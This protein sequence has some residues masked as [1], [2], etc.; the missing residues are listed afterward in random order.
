MNN[1]TITYG[2]G[3]HHV[4]TDPLYQGDY[5]QQI[6]FAGIDGLPASFEVHFSNEA[7]MGISTRAI[8]LDSVVNIPNMYLQTGEVS[9]YGWVFLHDPATSGETEYTFRIPVKKKPAADPVIPTPPQE[10]VIAE[11]INAINGAAEDAAQSATDAQTAQGLAEDARD[12]AQV[13][14]GKAEDAQE[15]AETA[16]GK[17]ED[18]Q[19]AAE[20][21]QG[22]AEDAQ[23]AAE[24]VAHSITDMTVSAS[25]LEPGS[26]ATVTKTFS[27]GVY[28]LVFGLPEGEKGDTGATG[29]TGAQGP[30]GETGATGA[31]GP[32][33][34][35]GAT[36]ATGAQGPRGE[37]GATG[38]T[39]DFSIG[40]VTTGAA[41]SSA[42]A[43]ITGTAAAPVLNLTIPK[44]DPG[45]ATIDDT[46]GDGDTDKVW[47]ADKCYDEV[48]DL[49]SHKSDIDGTYP[50][51][52]SGN[53]LQLL[54][55][56]GTTDKV[57]YFFRPSFAGDR[58]TDKLV[59]GSI[60]WN[61]LIQ[62]GKAPS[63]PPWDARNGT[64]TAGENESVY[65]VTTL[66]T[67][68]SI[69]VAING[70]ANHVYLFSVDVNP[71]HSKTALDMIIDYRT[72]RSSG[73]VS[74]TQGRWSTI[75]VVSLVS[76]ETGLRE[77]QIFLNCTEENGY[78]VGDKDK[79][80]NFMC[81][82][83][84]KMFGS[85]IANYIYSLEQATAGAGV[86]W[87]KKLFPKPYYAYNAGEIMS[88]SGVSAHQMTGFNQWDE[89][90]EQGEINTGT[91]ADS[92]STEK[93][94]SKNYI[95]ISPDW[96]Y[97]AKAP[98]S[99]YL[100]F[101]DAE[102]NY[103]GFHGSSKKDSVFRPYELSNAKPNGTSFENAV[104]MRF[105]C[106][107]ST[108]NHDICI[109]LHWDGE[110]D[111][112]YEPYV[113][114]S[115]ALD[116]S[117]T[118]RGIPKLDANNSL[119]YDGD[120]YEADGT[121]TRRY[122]ALNLGTKTWTKNNHATLGTYFYASVSGVKY[123]GNF[124]NIAYHALSS[125]YVTVPRNSTD[126]VDK[127][128]CFDG[129]MGAS[130]VTQIQ[131]KDSAY[132]DASTFKTAM[133]GVYLVYEFTTPTTE[134]ADPFQTPQIVDDWGTE[135]YVTTS[136]V[137]VG[138]DT[139]YPKNL[140]SEIERVSDQIPKA[141]S[142]N[143]TYKLRCVVSGGVPTY[144]WVSDS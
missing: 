143:G 103:I 67:G 19:T 51:L 122:V 36:G 78:S 100:F 37:T 41:G 86:A 70:P 139:K 132:S 112:E 22:K 118:L 26:E 135:E 23:E 59:G 74:L 87:F 127:T 15:A 52:T 8:G 49:K 108:Y 88:V 45:D 2:S 99:L 3:V 119:Y 82:D 43:T 40:T 101:Y 140:R 121:V 125:N 126:F 38:A 63:S 90:W 102:K 53:A 109:N 71:A 131:I 136:L 18:A 92:S 10:D 96:Q 14:Q 35:T 77:L 56:K 34:E 47:S 110:R 94:R 1:I 73:W 28:H 80:R 39:P 114:H 57:P 98:A 104:Y 106:D 17:A 129:N 68:K 65:E 137:P 66:S 4:V 79:V 116:D 85:T 107:V 9:I 20:T 75:S 111:G 81:F 69:D 97:Y 95:L 93:I 123:E 24:A 115:Y 7:S 89:E 128:L 13:A 124:Q 117:L 105:R 138:H 27:E 46:A 61:Q 72:N 62:N 31:T 30:K 54:T 58:E 142:S 55:D 130:E 83:L 91:G 5:G 25:T 133:N 32:R 64:L 50:D 42:S 11:A 76:S 16:Q 33:G 6:T 84:T 113:K 21:A 12:A 141:P 44:G 120:T 144:S 48:T 29:A 134:E 60:A